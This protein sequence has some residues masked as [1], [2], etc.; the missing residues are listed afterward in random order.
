MIGF[1]AVAT[2]ATVAIVAIVAIG[3]TGM[4]AGAVTPAARQIAACPARIAPRAA[5]PAG[6]RLLGR[7]PPAGIGLAYASLTGG[8]PGDVSDDW[9]MAEMEA[10]DSRTQGLARTDRTSFSATKTLPVTIAC[11][12]AATKTLDPTRDALLLLP[13]HTGVS[14]TCRFHADLTARP[15]RASTPATMICTA[16]R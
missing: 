1:P 12:Y 15:G 2:V 5:L 16:A 14:G 10:D 8:R 6:A 11:H 3:F 13:L 9:T 7:V 4:P